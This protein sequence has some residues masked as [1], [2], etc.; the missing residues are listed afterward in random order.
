[1]SPV[2]THVQRGEIQEPTMNDLH[3]DGS[4]H[5]ACPICG[6]CR[7]CGDCQSLGCGGK[8]DD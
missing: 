7:E 4:H 5:H 6:L 2:G 8:D 1:M 3:G